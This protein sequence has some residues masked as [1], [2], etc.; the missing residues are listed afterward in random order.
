MASW[1]T[2]LLVIVACLCGSACNI[3]HGDRLTGE[4]QSESVAAPFDRT[5]RDLELERFRSPD[6]TIHPRLDNARDPGAEP[7]ENEEASDPPV[8]GAGAGGPSE[9]QV[10]ADSDRHANEEQEDTDDAGVALERATPPALMDAGVHDADAGAPQMIETGRSREVDAGTSREVDA[11]SPRPVA[12]VSAA[13]RGELGYEMA[14]R[15]Y[16]ML[17]APVSW[18]VGRDRCYEHDAHLA[19]VTSKL[20]SDFIASFELEHDVWIGFSRFGAA[21]F[22]WLTSE[23]A[24]FSNW[25]SGAPRAMQESGALIK[26]RTGLWTN[27][28]VSELHPALCE[29]ESKTTR[30]GSK[31]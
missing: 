12:S 16:F 6:I 2:S 29:T 10:P 13:C 22:S 5:F 26:A 19:S 25:Q 24:S 23:S 30:R 3:Y 9:T 18:N 7:P 31:R 1:G 15:C 28:V 20:E 21:T 8:A 11:G 4:Q 17:D 14:G 27:R